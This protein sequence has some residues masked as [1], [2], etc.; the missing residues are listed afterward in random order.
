MDGRIAGTAQNAEDIW[1]LLPLYWNPFVTVRLHGGDA[2]KGLA[3]HR[4]STAGAELERLGADKTIGSVLR[5]V[6]SA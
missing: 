3:L 6:I 2:D 4:S 5:T 1:L